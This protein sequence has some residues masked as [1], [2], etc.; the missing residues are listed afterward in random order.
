MKGALLLGLNEGAV[1][2]LQAGTPHTRTDPSNGRTLVPQ[3][4]TP[5]S[6]T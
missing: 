5:T 2:I 3:Y 1:D 6:A 4:S